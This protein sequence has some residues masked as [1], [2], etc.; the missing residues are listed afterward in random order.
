MFNYLGDVIRSMLFNFKS[1]H[2]KFKKQKKEV[3]YGTEIF[4]DLER[5]SSSVCYVT[6][7]RIRL[8]IL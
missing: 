1:R 7:S 4:I 6:Y 3:G 5:M 8:F 2:L